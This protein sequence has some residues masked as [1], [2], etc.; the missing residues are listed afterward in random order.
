VLIFNLTGACETRV[1]PLLFTRPHPMMASLDTARNG[2][3]L[4]LGEPARSLPL[5]KIAAIVERGS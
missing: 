2:A 3:V 5:A 4:V 1:L